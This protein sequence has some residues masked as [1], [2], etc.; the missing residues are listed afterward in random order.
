MKAFCKVSLE[1]FLYQNFY[2]KLYQHMLE[3]V[4]AITQEENN[5]IEKSHLI[6]SLKMKFHLY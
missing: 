1:D 4:F 2:L 6:E 3:L 5:C